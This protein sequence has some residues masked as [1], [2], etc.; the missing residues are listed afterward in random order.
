MQTTIVLF[1]S[2]R[3]ENTDVAPLRDNGQLISEAQQKYEI[4]NRQFR[5][6]FTAENTQPPT[7]GNSTYPTLDTFNITQAGVLK[8][9]KNFNPNNAKGPDRL[10]PKLL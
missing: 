4:L 9:L 7:M 5:S 1:K 2:K 6:V 3:N 8:L 10:H